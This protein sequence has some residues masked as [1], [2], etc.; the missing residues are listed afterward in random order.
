MTMESA[1][2]GRVRSQFLITILS[3]AASAVLLAGFEYYYLQ[4]NGVPSREA[5]IPLW[6]PFFGYQ[7]EVF[8]PVMAILCFQL[9]LREGVRWTHVE[10]AFRQTLALGGA[11]LGLGLLLEDSVWFVFRALAPMASDPLA[12]NWILPADPTA[13]ALGS[14]SIFGAVVPLWYIVLGTPVVAVLVALFILPK[15]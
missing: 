13:N 10:W 14:A 2:H 5:S 6:G 11:C 4:V 15:D 3:V 12:H 8:L 7:A 1:S 9:V